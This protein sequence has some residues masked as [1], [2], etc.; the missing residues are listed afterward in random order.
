MQQ[1][2][3]PDRVILW[4]AQSQFPNKELPQDLLNLQKYGLEIK[5]CERDIK[6]YKKLIP[7]LQE[8]PNDIIITTDDDY[9]Y[10]KRLVESL[11][12]EYL[13]YP[14]CII[15]RQAFVLKIGRDKLFNMNARSYTYDSTYLPSFKNE[16]VGCG[17]VLYPPKSLH[18][19]ILNIEQFLKEI[20]THDD[21]WFWVHALRNGTK[22]KVLKN[23]H[24]LKHIMVEGSQEDSLWQKNMINSTST[25][26]MTGKCALN[27]VCEMFPEANKKLKNTIINRR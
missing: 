12:N 25:V 16:P 4:L 27:K 3:K 17:G 2:L 26:G 9:Y 10:D 22:I 1:T 13:K 15:A 20:P 11:Y 18:E 21:L 7:T 5:W 14:H 23:A 24:E 6:S 8:C 19:N